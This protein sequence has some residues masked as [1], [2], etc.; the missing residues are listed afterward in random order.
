MAESC[1][2]ILEKNRPL[3][4]SAQKQFCSV[5]NEQRIFVVSVLQGED[6]Q[7]VKDCLVVGQQQLELSPRPPGQPSLEVNMGYD[8]SGMVKVMVKDL[9]SGKEETITANFYK[10]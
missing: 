1:S 3:P 2:V 7:P 8:N 9:V 5:K 10:K 4:C 6:G